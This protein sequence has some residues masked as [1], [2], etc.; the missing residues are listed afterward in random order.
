VEYPVPG[1]YAIGFVTSTAS[2]EAGEKLGKRICNVYVPKAVNPI[3]GYLLLV[4][5]ERVRYL[6]MTPEEAMKMVVS[7]GALVPLAKK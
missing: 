6:E 1:S 5:E 4:P 7:A 2:G 3:T